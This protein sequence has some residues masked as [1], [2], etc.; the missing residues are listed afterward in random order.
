MIKNTVTYF[1]KVGKDNTEDTLK[2]EGNNYMNNKIPGHES[3]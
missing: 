3:G 2:L 1:E